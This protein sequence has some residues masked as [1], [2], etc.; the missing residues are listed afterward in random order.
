[1]HQMSIQAQAVVAK[2]SAVKGRGYTSRL[3]LK[4]QQ[5]DAQETI[6]SLMQDIWLHKRSQMHEPSHSSL[7]LHWSFKSWLTSKDFQ[8][9]IHS[10]SPVKS[11]FYLFI[12][13][14]KEHIFQPF[15][16]PFSSTARRRG[17]LGC[18]VQ[19]PKTRTLTKIFRARV[20]CDKVSLDARDG[21]HSLPP[22]SHQSL[23]HYFNSLY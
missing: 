22:P 18:L 11:N 5:E 12:L 1:M 17:S 16:R 15:E 3:L 10:A 23:C 9:A 7:F 21:P 13:E 19:E 8:K 4:K 20:A 14:S 2:S 6:L